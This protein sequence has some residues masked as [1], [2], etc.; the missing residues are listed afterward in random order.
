MWHV[1]RLG[2]GYQCR[3]LVYYD[4]HRAWPYLSAS[5]K[6]RIGETSSNLQ[7]MDQE[8]PLSLTCSWYGNSVLALATL[9]TR[10]LTMTWG[11]VDW[12]RRWLSLGRP[13]EIAILR[14]CYQ[15]FEVRAP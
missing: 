7:G 2:G 15:S 6:G 10:L 11:V 4:F 13:N 8:C 9:A 5:W 3:D 1:Y 14:L 12:I